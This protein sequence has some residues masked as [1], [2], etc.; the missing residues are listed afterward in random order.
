MAEAKDAESQM[1]HP[2]R[3]PPVPPVPPVQEAEARGGASAFIVQLLSQLSG[4]IYQLFYANAQM[5][6]MSAEQD[7]LRRR[8]HDSAIH[9]AELKRERFKSG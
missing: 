2:V 4:F 3:E 1:L 9:I 8:L 6:Q 5:R 7:N